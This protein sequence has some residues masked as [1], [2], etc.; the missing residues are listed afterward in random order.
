MASLS[1]PLVDQSSTA[2][3]PTHSAQ[4]RTLPHL[5]ATQ[6]CRLGLPLPHQLNLTRSPSS[7]PNCSSSQPLPSCSASYQASSLARA[8][9]DAN[10]SPR[11]PTAF[12]PQSKGKQAH[13]SPSPTFPTP[14]RP[15]FTP[16]DHLNLT[17]PLS[18]TQMVLLPKD[19]ELPRPLR[20]DQGWPQN[21]CETRWLDRRLRRARGGRRVG[22]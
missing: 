4:S 20:R 9:Q 16:R 17:R 10:S 12:P 1:V 8:S 5:P 22:T 13:S 2:Y 3:T 6:S 7:V 11:T 21:G 19:E 15:S 14:H 18:Q